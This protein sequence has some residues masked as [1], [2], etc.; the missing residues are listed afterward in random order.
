[1]FKVAIIFISNSMALRLISDLMYPKAEGGLVN[2]WTL[3][4]ISY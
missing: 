1:M 3:G 4:K 2:A